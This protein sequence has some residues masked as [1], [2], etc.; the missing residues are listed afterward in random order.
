MGITGS[1]RV[2]PGG[3]MMVYGSIKGEQ[4][5][6]RGFVYLIPE[7][8]QV[9]WKRT[10]DE[11]SITEKYI[12]A[13]SGIDMKAVHPPNM[14]YQE[15]ADYKFAVEGRDKFNRKVIKLYMCPNEYTIESKERQVGEWYLSGPEY[16]HIKNEVFD[17]MLKQAAIFPAINNEPRP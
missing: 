4:C 15:V 7:Y 1:K 13:L 2:D 14:K 3:E 6:H 17:E 8:V 10:G 5:R 12:N 11:L 9:S 16:D